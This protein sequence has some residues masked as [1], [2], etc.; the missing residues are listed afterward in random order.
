MTTAPLPSPASSPATGPGRRLLAL[1][2][3]AWCVW[4]LAL[5]LATVLEWGLGLAIDLRPRTTPDEWR[6]GFP[7]ADPEFLATFAG[8]MDHTV[9]WFDSPRAS[10]VPLVWEPFAYWRGKPFTGQYL[11][12]AADGTRATP[13]PERAARG[14][15]EWIVCLGGSTMWG[16]G[17]R[18][19]GTIP[20]RLAVELAALDQP[21]E[22]V[23]LAQIGYVASQEVLTL[24]RELAQGRVP[25][26][27]VFLDGY[28]DVAAGVW[29][30]QPGRSLDDAVRAEEFLASRRSSRELVGWALQNTTLGRLTAGLRASPPTAGLPA[31]GDLRP[32]AA[33]IWQHYR[34]QRSLVEAWAEHYG[35]VALFAWQPVI[36][37]KNQPS[38]SEAAALAGRQGQAELCRAVYDL[39]R[40]DRGAGPS[41]QPHEPTAEAPP[42]STRYLYLGEA[43]N[44]PSWS[45]ETAFY[46]RCHLVESAQAELARRLAQELARLLTE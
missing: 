28:N 21:A 26:A 34:G 41:D 14:P 1:L 11:N 12:V 5:L 25:R 30:R 6:V 38:A 9:T 39:A 27:V 46:D 8:E 29:N 44:Q 43:F 33:A 45:G 3:R 36:Y 16:F 4:G 13:L 19:A 7:Q 35:F 22:V 2:A 18:D 17:A 31:D 32:W 10:D 20:A 42:K 40:D 23:N 24:G 15:S 37:L